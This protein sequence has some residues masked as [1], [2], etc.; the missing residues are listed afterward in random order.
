MDQRLQIDTYNIGYSRVE[1][2]KPTIMFNEKYTYKIQAHEILVR[3][4]IMK[5]C[6]V[7]L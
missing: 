4:T 7:V 1:E 2:S 3:Y 6:Y 5:C